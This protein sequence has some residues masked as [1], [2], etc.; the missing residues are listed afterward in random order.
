MIV[1]E[2]VGNSMATQWTQALEDIKKSQFV[3]SP[4]SGH[5]KRRSQSLQPLT[6]R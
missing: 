1:K 6:K 4:P 5:R 2:I 3:R